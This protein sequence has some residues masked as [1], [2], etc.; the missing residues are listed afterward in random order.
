MKINFDF[1]KDGLSSYLFCLFNIRGK[2][3]RVVE[4]EKRRWRKINLRAPVGIQWLDES[5]NWLI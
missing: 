1:L 3:V 4:L 5:L 2:H